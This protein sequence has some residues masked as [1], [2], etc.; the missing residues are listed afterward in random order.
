MANELQMN[1]GGDDTEILFPSSLPCLELGFYR[2]RR[3][4][5]CADAIKQL[6]RA[7][8]SARSE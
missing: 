8:V 1:D 2:I 6:R 7:V 4:I 3:E 5:S